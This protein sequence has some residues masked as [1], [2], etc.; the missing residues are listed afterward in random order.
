MLIIGIDLGGTKISG[1]VFDENGKQLYQTTHLLNRR[2]GSEVGQLITETI[3]EL[4]PTKT[5][6][7][8]VQAIGICVPGISHTKTGR[9]WVPNIPGWESYPLQKEVEDFLNNPDIHVK[10]ASDRSC[11]ILGELWKGVAQGV[12]DALFVAVGT[13]IGIGILANG[14][15][16]EG[17]TY[18]S[19][20]AG[21]MALD[22]KFEDDYVQYG[23]FESCA[24]GN[25]I[26]RCARQLLQGNASFKE[27][28]LHAYPIDK[29]TTYEIFKAW[30]MNDP[31]AVQ[32]IDRAVQ[33]WGMAAANLVSLFNPEI[34]VWGGGVFGPAKKLIDRIY[35]EAR[36]W[37]QPIAI[38][39]V[40]FETSL[41]KGEA[42][43]HG[44]GYLA[45]MDWEKR[46]YNL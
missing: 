37:A 10:I 2:E 1:A 23:C 46:K 35:Q 4:L 6:L 24:S 19:G 20:A 22:P 15:I 26:A 11:Y 9:V 38:R 3:R 17:H 7:S 39:Q 34:I 42:G 40:R 8:A 12:K 45:L 44:A 16:L 14:Q 5:V 25:G 41:L 32:V 18:T 29:I 30:E 27:S 21:W 36:R 13:G 43:L 28:I 33:M 31:L